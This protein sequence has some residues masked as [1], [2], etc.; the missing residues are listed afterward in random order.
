MPVIYRDRSIVQ[1]LWDYPSFL[2]VPE[3]ATIY[4]DVRAILPGEGLEVSASGIRPFSFKEQ[5]PVP[6]LPFDSD[7]DAVASV[8]AIAEEAVRS[9]LLADV[10]IGAFLSGGLDSSIVC[11]LATKQI[12][13]LHTFCIGFERVHDPYHGHSDESEQAEA[14]ARKLGPGTRRVRV[15]GRDFRDLLPRFLASGGTALRGVL[16]PRDP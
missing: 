6:A 9:R 2:W 11:T 14:Y 1:A 4:R 16:G 3:P 7:A 12:P 8:R 15:T 10:E 13:N 5:I